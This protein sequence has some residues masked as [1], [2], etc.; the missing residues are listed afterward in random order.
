MLEQCAYSVSSPAAVVDLNVVAVAAAPAVKTVGNDDSSV[1]G[2]EN[3]R[4]LGAGNVGA[5]VGADLAGDGVYTMSELWVI[6]PATGS[7]HCNV[8]VRGAGAVWIHKF[9]TTLCKTAEQFRPQLFV[10]RVLQ[11]LQIVVLA[12]GKVIIC[13]HFARRFVG[14]FD[15]EDC[16]GNFCCGRFSVLVRRFYNSGFRTVEQFIPAFIAHII[17]PQLVYL[18]LCQRRNGCALFIS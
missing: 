18:F 4:A 16:F 12:G 5:G 9:S 13:C 3:R 8:P 7:G 15:Y 17:S 6:V 14:Q 11:K 10:L 1:C 2:G